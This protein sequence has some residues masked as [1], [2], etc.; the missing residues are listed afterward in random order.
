MLSSN[1]ASPSEKK[2][3]FMASMSVC[4]AT[5][6]FIWLL[7]PGSA[8]AQ[9][10][11]SLRGTVTDSS[12]AV[13]PS[14]TVSVAQV[15]TGFSRNVTTNTEGDY[16]IPALPPADY[17][18][19]AQA[20]GFRQITRKGLTLLADK[21]VTV[22]VEMEVGDA[23]QTVTVEAA[24]TQ[25]DTTTGTQSQVINQT[26]MVELPLNGRNAAELSLLV[27]GASPPPAGGGGSLQGVS[28]QF[29]S[30]IAVSTNGAQE[31]QVSY[32]LDGGTFMD[33]FFSVN[34]PFPLPD[35]LQEF[36]VETSNYAAQYGSNSG[37]V[38]NII[39]KS[40]SNAIH[41]DVF[42]FNRN[43][44]FNARNFFA[45]RRDQLKRNQFG[46]T[47]GGP[48]VIPK[49]YN[50]RDRTFW[51]FGYQGTR[52]KN[53]GGTSS[54]FVPTPANLNGDFSAYL[55]ATNPNNPLGRAVQVIDPNTGQPFPGN[56]IPVSRLDP[57]ALGAEKYLPKPTGTG[58][59]FSQTPIVQNLD[60]TVERFD[61]SFSS[62]DRL[63]FRGTWNNF[64]NQA[65]F[66]PR[67][68]LTLSSGSKITSQNYLLHEI[69]LFRSNLLND[70]R[71]TYWRLKSSRG[72]APG[73][74]NV[75]DFGVQN[76]FQASPKSVQG[77][78]VS[79]FFGFSESP[80][81]AF[82]RQGFTW[83]DDLSWTH[84]PH[85]FQFGI[86][87]DRSRFDLVN[88][89]AMDGS[90]TFTSDVTNL[91][92]ASFLLGKMRT[93]TQGSG[94]P[95]NLRDIFLGFYAQD[96][97]RVSKRLT[98]NYGVRYEP[99]IPW[100]EIR[101]RFNYFR[102]ADYYA[103]IHSKVFPNAP[104]G[105]LF[106]G[107]AGVPPRIGWANDMNN[108]MPRFG[109]A[110]DVFGDGKTSIR[111]GGGLFY[112]TRISGAM[113]NTIT[114]VGT[115]NVAPFAPTIIITNPQG[116]FSNPYLGIANP[117]PAPQPPP[118][119]VTF[120]TP[121]AVASVD[122]AHRNLVTPLEYNWNLGIERQIVPGW[123]LRVAYVGSH[124]SHLRDLV[125]LNPA[126]YIPGSA[127]SPDQRRM[128][129][130][131][132]T[133]YQT[134]MDTNAEY[135]SAQVSLEKR[136][137]QSGFLHGVTLLAN[138][139]FS[140][141]IDT[142]PVSGNVIG[143]GVSTIPFWMPGRRNM[144][145]GLSD[146]NH[147]HRMVISYDWPLPKLA[148]LNWFARGLLGGWE[149]TGLLSAQSG[150]PFTVVAGQDQSQTAIGQDRAVV[151]GAPY[152]PG[153]C[154]SKAPCV[155]FLN[156][157]AFALPTVG[158]FGNVGKDALIGPGLVTWDMGFFK[159][160]PFQ[161]RYRIQVRAEFFNTLNRANFGNPSSAVN[162]G[163]FGSI[164]SAADPRIGQLA[165]KF[166][167]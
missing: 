12:G 92:L 68:V 152:G 125:Q 66:D 134:S 8:L 60:E 44:V 95:E 58:Q 13:I 166:L 24:P 114:G 5:L 107:D 108:V 28:K 82:V 77:V 161:E 111:G 25:V 81:A 120:P 75:T 36:S 14:A 56:I 63:T 89:V 7:L 98:L 67:N 96:S 106:Q 84:G 138:Y 158:T 51:F 115:G 34:L 71:V 27:A 146:F 150:F 131:Y 10:L 117:F 149:L 57:A 148:G 129:P 23:T 140:K 139:T 37:G 87:A 47:L 102:P 42:E 133:I 136:V 21:S 110:W 159:N 17:I 33:E 65:V 49:L 167:F 18:L 163:A 112:D 26:Q 3:R 103:G 59:V 147:T 127:L 31:D 93:F 38:V 122:G 145:R 20:N 53:I 154:G 123:L 30:Q 74:P 29:P 85:N 104:V 99:G 124:G 130:G 76:I 142:A 64:V 119:N 6:V 113:L 4:L 61:H 86:S 48:V 100:N 88:N 52:L 41:G 70:F 128:F 2:E 43:A 90:F 69:H 54:A 62:A 9:G 91:A 55:D 156:R 39:T 83:A 143:T 78:S 151:V 116:P 137:G 19:T 16:L 118:I 121:L 46:F 40:G 35:A 162:A 94:Q 105:L 32:Q 22:N 157:N 50:G 11:A 1:H 135:N 141:S 80:F 164:T 45:A 144:D 132:S 165:L 79:G 155:D 101:G 153:A 97:F 160:F 126:I 15:G 109:F 72:P 73:S